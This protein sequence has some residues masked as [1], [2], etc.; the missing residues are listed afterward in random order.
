MTRDQ[1]LEFTERVGSQFSQRYG[2]PP[3]TGRTLGWLLVCDPPTQ[4]ATE[5]AEELRASRGGI[6]NAVTM[7]ESMGYVKRRRPTG[8]RTDLIEVDPS[9]WASGL[10]ASNEFQVLADLADEGLRLLGDA[11][12]GHRARLVEMAAFAKFFAGR[13]P[14]VFAEWRERREE[15]QRAG[16]L[17]TSNLTPGVER[18]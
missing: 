15:L 18:R 8:E 13:M 5:I 4:T 3:L 6:S 12:L 17:S 9:V 2:L 11:E 10:D 1:L 16:G 7:L 14:E